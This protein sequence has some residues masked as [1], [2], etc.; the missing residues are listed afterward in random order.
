MKYITGITFFILTL[1]ACS[2]PETLSE[3]PAEIVEAETGRPSWYSVNRVSGSDESHFMGYSM[4]TAVDSVEAIESGM[5]SALANLRFEIDKYAEEVREGL[6]PDASNTPLR[7][8]R[9]IIEL[10]NAIQELELSKTE[11]EREFGER[12]DTIIQVYTRV[13]ASRSDII[14]DL[15]LLLSEESFI[16]AIRAEVIEP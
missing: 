2:T 11:F 3:E 7:S 1:A 6:H 13:S 14:E 8:P 10:R 5:E 4:T 9:F 15:S 16:R 12:E